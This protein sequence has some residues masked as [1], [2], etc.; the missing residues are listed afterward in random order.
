MVSKKYYPR[1]KI[2]TP[3]Q[4][5]FLVKQNFSK[6]KIVNNQGKLHL[7]ISLQPSVFSPSYPIEI[8]EYSRGKYDTWLIG[9]IQKIDD[10]KFPHKYEVDKKNNKVRLCLYHPNRGEWTK[11]QEIYNTLIPWTCEWLYYYE[12]WLDDGKWRGGGEHPRLNDRK[13]PRR[14]N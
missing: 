1:K 13:R 7:Y 11:D 6:A 9:N 14:N 12:L 5:F 2:L 4:Q 3:I 10:P 8:I